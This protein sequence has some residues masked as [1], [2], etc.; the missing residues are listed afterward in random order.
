MSADT[1]PLIHASRSLSITQGLNSSDGLSVTNA[2][3]L[4][5]VDLGGGG[6]DSSVWQKVGSPIVPSFGS[7]VVALPEMGAVLTAS[8]DKTA[9]LWDLRSSPAKAQGT[10]QGAAHG[11]GRANSSA[12]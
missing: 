7:A 10:P 9:R 1:F 12:R 8:W 4:L 5:L 11:G 2:P 3:I 6:A